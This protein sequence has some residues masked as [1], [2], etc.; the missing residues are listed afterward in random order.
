MLC[1]PNPNPN[2]NP[3]LIAND[4]LCYA[5]PSPNPNPNPTPIANDI[6][7]RY[8]LKGTH[9]EA[10]ADTGILITQMTWMTEFPRAVAPAVKLVGPILPEPA[11]YVLVSM[12]LGSLATLAALPSCVVIVWRCGVACS[13]CQQNS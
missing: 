1:H 2:P 7:K 10:M 6:R 12:R 4:M 9:A 8:G 11:S 3:T 13:R 5:N